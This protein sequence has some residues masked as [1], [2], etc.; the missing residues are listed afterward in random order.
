M[1]L[2]SLPSHAVAAA[3]LWLML[4]GCVHT[5]PGTSVKVAL[6]KKANLVRMAGAPTGVPARN[7]STASV[8]QVE[9]DLPGSD[10]L[11]AVAEAFSRGG[12]CMSAG[13]DAE[14]IEAFEQVVKIDPTF[15][16]AWQNLALLHEKSGDDRKA[17]EA[18]RKAKNIAKH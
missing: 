2:R 13:K 1:N 12:F 3:G 5:P 7:A 11:E 15:T 8:P 6:A 14:A 10:H 17:L 4:V 18:F 16:E 9:P